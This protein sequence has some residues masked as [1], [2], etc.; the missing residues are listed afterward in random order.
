MFRYR[1]QFKRRP[2]MFKGIL[3]SHQ[4]DPQRQ[5]ALEKEIDTL[6]EKGAIRE[7]K[8]SEQQTGFYS[9]YFLVPKRD[10]MFRPILD[11]RPLN[12]YLRPFQDALH[13]ADHPVSS[14]GGLVHEHRPERCLLTCLCAT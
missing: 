6:L 4:P 7:L 9:S 10:G 12:D 3:F 13:Q 14:G 1:L 11:L 2:P 5:L 8:Q